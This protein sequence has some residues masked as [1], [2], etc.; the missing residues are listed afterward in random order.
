MLSIFSKRQLFCFK[1]MGIMFVLFFYR[2]SGC[3][4]WKRR[5]RWPDSSADRRLWNSHHTH[6]GWQFPAH[7][8]VGHAGPRA[9]ELAAAKFFR[10]AAAI[11]IGNLSN[12]PPLVV[13]YS[14]PLFC[15]QC[16]V[17]ANRWMVLPLPRPL[18]SGQH[19][20]LDSSK[21]REGREA[22]NQRRRKTQN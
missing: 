2:W 1:S 16:F 8:P 5:C 17:I 12:S 13:L 14:F 19:F 21:T 3:H 6:D 11:S 15:P 20:A 9:V 22:F 18:T 10:P 4:G 7:G